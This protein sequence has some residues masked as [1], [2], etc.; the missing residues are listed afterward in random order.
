MSGLFS[1]LFASLIGAL[2]GDL[3]AALLGAFSGAV[4][5][6]H[7]F[8]R[9]EQKK[10]RSATAVRLI[11]E[12]TSPSFL[13]I[14]NDGGIALRTAL[15][16]GSKSWQELYDTLPQNEWR[17]ISKI[18]HF[19]QKLDLMLEI[20][21]ADRNHIYAYFKKEFPHWYVKYLEGVL[22]KSEDATSYRHLTELF[23]DE[24]STKKLE[25]ESS[26]N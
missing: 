12:Y 6:A 26:Q 3:G 18:E 7:I 17:K 16:D 10:E 19:Y 9:V 13:D 5:S 23:S 2:S 11:E 1:A 4:A 8:N 21:V 20:H 15:K 14:R 25:L 24:I 22:K